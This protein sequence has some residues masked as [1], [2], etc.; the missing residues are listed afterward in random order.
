M[1]IG[2]FFA[3]IDA[4]LKRIRSCLF[5][6]GLRTNEQTEIQAF[7]TEASFAL[8][9]AMEL[10]SELLRGDW[11]PS[12]PGSVLQVDAQ[13]DHPME[14]EDE[15]IFRPQ[16]DGNRPAAQ[17][18]DSSAEPMD[19]LMRRLKDE[20]VRMSIEMRQ[21]L[22]VARR[23]L[24][25]IDGSG[26]GVD[27]ATQVAHMRQSIDRA[28]KLSD[29]LAAIMWS[30]RPPDHS[31][32]SEKD[33]PVMPVADLAES[34]AASSSGGESGA[35]DSE[36]DE[37]GVGIGRALGLMILGAASASLIWSLAFFAR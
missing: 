29:A 4:D 24:E 9:H 1:R 30:D 36:V 17:S 10:S 15:R 12:T 23:H 16:E 27:S 18:G 7:V 32:V 31:I 37:V 34:I 35:T 2:Q 13:R 22:E 3:D 8:T 25:S 33:P 20:V 26:A 21:D 28:L 19:D 6:I 5:S 11:R 14:E